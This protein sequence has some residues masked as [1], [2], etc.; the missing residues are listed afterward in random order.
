MWLIQSNS[1]RA[2]RRLSQAGLLIAGGTLFVSTAF[3]AAIL[4]APTLQT[5][6][7][8][9]AFK[10][11]KPEMY[12]AGW[13][14]LNKNNS[15]EPYENPSVP[16][17]RRVE[18]LL[19]RMNQA[20][21]IGQLWQRPLADARGDQTLIARGGLGSY[22][23]VDMG[24][25]GVRNSLQRVA[26]EESRLG[27]PLIFGYDTIH[28]FRTVFPIPLALSC[29]WDPALLERTSAI[30]ARESKA[31]G[32]DWTFAPMIDIARDPRWGRIAEGNG[33]DPWLTSQLVA[34]SIRGFQGDNAG[35]S[36][37]VAACLKHYVGYGAAE[38]GRDYNTTEI[39]VPTLR[40]IYLPPFKAGVDA[41]ALTI[42]SAF[43][44]LNGIPTSGNRFTLT[45]ILRDEWKFAG[46]VVSD[47]DSVKETIRHGF[48]EDEADAARI[49][50]TA[51]V[52]IEMVSDT[53]RQ[54]LAGL[55]AA[56]TV[57][58]ATL[59][60]A[61]R[62]V[63][64]LKIRCG[65]FE[66]PYTAT[67][68]K[69][70]LRSDALKLSREAAARSAVLVKNEGAILPLKSGA[71]VALIGPYGDSHDLLGCWS[72]V[73]R[74]EEAATLATAL[75]VFLGTNALT[76]A[77]GCEMHTNI[78]EGIPAALEAARAADVI[79][80]AI[81]EPASLS[82]EARSRQTLNLPGGQE[83]LL[84]RI[85]AL[86]KPVVAVL[87]T[88]RPL[89]V[90]EVLE[91]CEAVLIAWHPGNEGAA[92]IADVLTGAVEP[93]GRLTASWPRTVGQIPIHYNHL[94]TSRTFSDQYG[95][96]YV[97]GPRTPLL[98]FGFGMGYG[99]FS[100]S[101]VKLDRDQASI[102]QPVTASAMLRN[103]SKRAGSTVVQLYIR[104]H[105]ASGGARPLRELRGYQRVAL[106]PGA[107][108]EIKF[109]LDEKT[110]GYW[111][112]NGIW[113]NEPGRFT[114]WIGFDS[115]TTNGASLVLSP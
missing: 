51:G 91:K 84:E 22:L 3:G 29:S 62:R 18:D 106:E 41:G 78:V 40:N 67:V 66:Q 101:A 112:P 59:D 109:N 72:A 88:G 85:T 48:A 19:N 92:G 68:E 13:V 98:P 53:Y 83:V 111:L 102:A 30:A 77:P 113:T 12:R 5:A 110:L 11:Q 34:G 24:G 70:F 104:D 25:P 1:L 7:N 37:R 63:L 94:A 61:V 14:D 114:T 45:E 69:P 86:G 75:K 33:E 100:L 71:R 32:V 38:G 65:L 47:Y 39:G 9:I 76:I 8:D 26:I 2:I 90:P 80:L 82:G 6:T 115:A 43:N 28:G 81:G 56:G 95:S 44:C 64:Q 31:A 97:D 21:K 87:F 103:T 105:S 108:R 23:G 4:E 96:H 99:T 57:S 60:E 50:L 89:A 46:T 74:N 20:D 35:A 36:D 52:D 54:H 55:I 42:M 79:V 93:T 49:G 73:G 10:L 17:E 15:Q 27:I 107:E 16:V 58:Q